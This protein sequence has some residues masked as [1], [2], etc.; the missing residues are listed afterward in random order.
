MFRYYKPI[1]LLTGFVLYSN[2]PL[3]AQDEFPQEVIQ[4]IASESCECIKK[5]AQGLDAEGASQVMQTCMQGAVMNHVSELMD[6]G[7]SD[8]EKAQELGVEV[9]NVLLKTCPEMTQMMS[10]NGTS[11]RVQTTTSTSRATLAEGTLKKIEK[12][13]LTFLLLESNGETQRYLWFNDFEGSA[14]LMNLGNQAVGKSVKIGWQI[15]RYYNSDKNTY[16]ST[17]EIKSFEILGN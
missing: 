3:L 10:G 6:Y 1:F 16:Q 7:L 11:T 12:G 5:D 17:R 4:M 2:L 15:R 8:P 13:P 14:E 9:A